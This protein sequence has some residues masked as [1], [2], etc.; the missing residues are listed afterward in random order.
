MK[1]FHRL[2]QGIALI[3][4]V[5][6]VMA[7]PAQIFGPS[8]PSAQLISFKPDAGETLIKGSALEVTAEVE[9]DPSSFE[10]VEFTSAVT[11]GKRSYH[12]ALTTLTQR[13]GGGEAKG[14]ESMTWVTRVPPGRNASIRFTVNGLGDASKKEFLFVDLNRQYLVKCDPKECWLLRQIHRIFGCCSD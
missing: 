1:I 3:F 8:G 2:A 13:T 4:P 10:S 7:A 5:G 9:F 6:Y 14:R 11:I 12:P